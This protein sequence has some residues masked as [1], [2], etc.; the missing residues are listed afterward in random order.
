MI[1]IKY[2][3]MESS[4]IHGS[5]HTKEDIMRKFTLFV[6]AA[7]ALLTA[8][9]TLS[10][11]KFPTKPIRILV[12]FA[13]GS[14]TDVLARTVGQKMADSL[15]QSVVVDNRAGASGVIASE[16]LARSLPDGHTLVMVAI[17]HAFNATANSKLPY[18]T[19]KD[20]AGV[21]MVADIPNVLVVSPVLRIKTMRELMDLAKSRQLSW[22]GAGVGSA[23]HLNGELFNLAANVKAVHVPFKGMAEALTSLVG[24]HVEFVFSSITAAVNLVKSDKLVALAVSSKTRSPALPDV[25]MMSEA[26]LPGFH[27]TSW[28]GLLV[29]GRTPKSIKDQ[30]SKEVARIL[31]LPDVRERLLALGAM[32]QA[33]SPEEFDEMIRQDIARLA[34]MIKDVGMPIQ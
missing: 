18:D 14:G 15:G 28:Y 33:T 7:A 27:F 25:P 24:Q 34:K 17:G 4:M 32:P 12:G 3:G 6:T 5:G 31:A 2:R 13:P 26:G 19:L 20:F 23:G 16:L 1:Q 29:P 22:A 9:A 8:N 21:T 30:L 11:D 10:Q